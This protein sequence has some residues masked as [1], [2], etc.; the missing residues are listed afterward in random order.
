[1]KKIILL[2]LFA[3]LSSCEVLQ[4]VDTNP[5]IDGNCKLIL[6]NWENKHITCEVDGVEIPI[7]PSRRFKLQLEEGK[8]TICF[9]GKESVFEGKNLVTYKKILK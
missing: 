7:K 5:M 9:N 6:I 3:F 8:H 1:M 2:F 4:L